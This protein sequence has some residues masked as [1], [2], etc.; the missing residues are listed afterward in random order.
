[1]IRFV[2]DLN[3]EIKKL[4]ETE[5]G[6]VGEIAATDFEQYRSGALAY[7]KENTEL[8]GFRKGHVPESILLERLGKMAILEEMAERALRDIYP[9]IIAENK[10]E[11]IDRPQIS[12]TKIADGN[13]L[14][15]K[16]LQTVLPEIKLPD[17]KAIT[18]GLKTPDVKESKTSGVDGER[19]AKIIEAILKETAIPLPAIIVEREL[20]NMVS[21]V[22]NKYGSKSSEVE[23][24]AGLRAVAE[25]R[26]RV[27]FLI[28]AIAK[29]EEIERE[30]V[31]ELLESLA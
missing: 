3:I 13:P 4:S 25:G 17:Y 16:I 7:L 24:R 5:V 6:I 31:F 23:L 26:I 20:E 19:R 30:K 21:D 2:L 28:E 27:G 29:A 22:K 1:M 9:K 15:F 10:I 18:K 11:A 12:I 8:P 14:G